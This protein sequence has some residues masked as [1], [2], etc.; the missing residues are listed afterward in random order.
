[1]DVNFAP[2]MSA[3]YLNDLSPFL[4]EF[5]N[6]MG[7]RWYGL[8]YLAAFLAGWWLYRH[9]AQ[10]GYSDLRPDQVGDFIFSSAIFGV[11]L[12]GR[13]GYVLFY[14]P[15][16]LTHDP[17]GIFKVWEG[18]MASHGGILG[19]FVFTWIYS[20]WKKISWLN[21]GD[22]LCVVAPVGIFFGRCANF[23]NGELYGRVAAVP[24]AVLFP[25]ELP[26]VDDRV[27]AIMREDLEVRAAIAAEL[28]PRHPSQLYEAFAEGILL[29]AALWLMR[30]RLRMRD[31]ALTGWF[32]ILYAVGRIVTECFR[33]PDAGLILGLSRGQFYSLFLIVI[34]LVFLLYA[35]RHGRSR[36]PHGQSGG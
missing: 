18:G 24:W 30:T 23:I 2:V 9:L 21:L 28:T 1:M 34:G 11:L 14:R 7:L 36:E 29:F 6:G 22:N 33:E 26:Q 17:L 15:D 16:I 35:R 27:L 3:Y 32:F 10:R 13:L 12:G 31:G 20:R 19:L 5:G 8:A 25:R 4:I